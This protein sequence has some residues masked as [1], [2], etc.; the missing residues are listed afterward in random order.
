MKGAHITQH[1]GLCRGG[2]D[3]SLSETDSFVPPMCIP[4]EGPGRQSL[5]IPSMYT[6]WMASPA[7]LAPVKIEKIIFM[8]TA[9]TISTVSPPE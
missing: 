2:V 6:I 1:H 4:I 8:A 9:C 5:I 7:A 3:Y